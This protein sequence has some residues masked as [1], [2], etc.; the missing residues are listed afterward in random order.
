MNMWGMLPFC[1]GFVWA[2][3]FMVLSV[4]WVGYLDPFYQ[5]AFVNAL[6]ISLAVSFVVGFPFFVARKRRR[7]SN[8]RDDKERT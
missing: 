7:K 3:L 1:V 4:A 2:V 5:F 6:L 8:R